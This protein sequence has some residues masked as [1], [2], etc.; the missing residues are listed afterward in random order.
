MDGAAAGG[1]ALPVSGFADPEFGGASPPETQY[2]SMN[3]TGGGSWREG[4]SA[5]R[6]R[7]KSCDRNRRRGMQCLK[8]RRAGLPPAGQH[9]GQRPAHWLREPVSA[10]C[11]SLAR[12]LRPGPVPCVCLPPRVV[13][14]TSKRGPHRPGHPGCVLRGEETGAPS[15]GWEAA[16]RVGEGGFGF[17]SQ[18]GGQS[19]P[20]P[21]RPEEGG[22]R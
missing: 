6:G 14:K 11:R 10:G 1:G 2:E 12:P 17:E 8:P 16:P 7:S 9:R 5:P 19:L 22:Q 21:V 18:V 13:G 15:G 3:F 4:F 20:S